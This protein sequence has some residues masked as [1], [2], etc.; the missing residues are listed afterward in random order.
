MQSTAA[1][2]QSA[3]QVSRNLIAGHMQIL[4]VTYTQMAMRSSTVS[5]RSGASM[6]RPIWLI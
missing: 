1:C 6:T 2:D 4:R 3:G 5:H